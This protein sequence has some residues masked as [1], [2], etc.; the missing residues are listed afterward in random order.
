MQMKTYQKGQSGLAIIGLTMALGITGL[1]LNQ[2]V[3]AGAHE[4]EVVH[5]TIRIEPKY[6]IQAANDNQ[7]GF[8][9]LQFD[10]SPSGAVSNVSVIK[11]SPEGVFDKSAVTA[12]KQWQY[13]ESRQGL[14]AAKVQLDFMID[15][16]ATDVERIKVTP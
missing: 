4:H 10:I 3:Q 2:Q 16:P 6:P 13:S 5:P 1:L 11:S 14:T 9:Q 7:S 15:P 12:L 8:V